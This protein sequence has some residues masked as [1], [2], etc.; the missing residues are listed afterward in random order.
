MEEENEI[1]IEELEEILDGDSV[2]DDDEWDAT[3]YSKE[4]IGFD[5]S[6]PFSPEDEKEIEEM[7]NTIK[8]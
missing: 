3:E 6:E 2:A 4:E 8:E 1:T 7:V 5:Y